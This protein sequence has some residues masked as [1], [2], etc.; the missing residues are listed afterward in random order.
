MF[1]NVQSEKILKIYAICLTKKILLM[2]CMN[3][4]LREESFKQL[5]LHCSNDLFLLQFCVCACA[6]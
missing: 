2:L 6:F 1:L 3:E 4:Y 5:K